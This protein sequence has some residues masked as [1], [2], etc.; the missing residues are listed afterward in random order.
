MKILIEEDYKGN[1]LGILNCLILVRKLSV[2]ANTVGANELIRSGILIYLEKYTDTSLKDFPDIQQESCWILSNISALENLDLEFFW[3]SKLIHNLLILLRSENKDTLMNSIWA[4][5]NLIGD[6]IEYRNRI[7][8]FG[9]IIDGFVELISRLKNK[10]DPM[11][12]PKLLGEALWFVSNLCR[13]PYPTNG[14]VFF[15]FNF[16]INLIIDFKIFGFN[17]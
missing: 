13:K 12:S 17:S 11:Y 9:G 16:K 15:F 8:E 1:I 10:Q 4:L 2:E 14:E 7:L 3:T 5:C 6:S